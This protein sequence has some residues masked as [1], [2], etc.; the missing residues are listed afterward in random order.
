M[1]RVLVIAPWRIAHARDARA[2]AAKDTG[3]STVQSQMTMISILRSLV[4]CAKRADIIIC[5]PSS[6][7]ARRSHRAD[8]R[9]AELHAQNTLDKSFPESLM[10]N[11]FRFYS[12]EGLRALR[13]HEHRQERAAATPAAECEGKH[14]FVGNR[15]R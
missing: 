2:S 7:L 6:A 4:V 5:Q 12:T 3:D 1:T 11:V 15:S 8:V 10:K 13:K 9:S 14:V